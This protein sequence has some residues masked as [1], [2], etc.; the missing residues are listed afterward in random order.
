MFWVFYIL[1]NLATVYLGFHYQLTGPLRLLI[2]NLLL[3]PL[4]LLYTLYIVFVV[5]PRLIAEANGEELP[6]PFFVP[7]L[8]IV[9]TAILKL[10]NY[11]LELLGRPPR[12]LD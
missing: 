8:E 11:L 12:R 9:R 6:L 4:G 10:W 5:R 7:Y 1:T 3:P 2:L